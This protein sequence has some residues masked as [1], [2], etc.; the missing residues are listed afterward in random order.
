MR[1]LCRDCIFASFTDGVQEGCVL[2]RLEKFKSLGTEVSIE[3]DPEKEKQYYVI[4]DRYCMACR[5]DKWLQNL[6]DSED[7]V[8]KMKDEM[9][10]QYSAIVFHNSS[11]K[12]LKQTLLSLE[13]QNP[14]PKNIKIVRKPSCEHSLTEI[15]KCCQTLEVK[16][17]VRNFLSEMNDNECIDLILKSPSVA[18]FYCVFYSGFD[19]PSDTM[20]NVNDFVNEK[21]NH[22]AMLLPNDSGNGMMVQSIVHKLCEGNS[23]LPLKEK[24]EQAEW[25]DKIIKM[26]EVSQSFPE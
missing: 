11:L 8:T 4:N 16:W 25:K 15:S 10:I 18:A 23:G 3:I 9:S 13:S 21:L 7:H 12:D 17:T 26:R 22:F 5:N 1:T 20:Y 6:D 24:M 14:K 19:V 2:G